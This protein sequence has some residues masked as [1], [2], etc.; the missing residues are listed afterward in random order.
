MYDPSQSCQQRPTLLVFKA[1]FGDESSEVDVIYY[2]GADAYVFLGTG[3]G[4]IRKRILNLQ[5]NPFK[6]E[7]IYRGVPGEPCLTF[8]KNVKLDV[9]L[10]I[11]P[12][13]QLILQNVELKFSKEIMVKPI[14]GRRTLKLL[15]YDKREILLGSQKRTG[16]ILIWKID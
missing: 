2:Q 7:Q 5:I 12:G 13:S 6:T 8:H 10:N 9:N 3:A 14:I 16:D 11:R 4:K 15:G 1:S